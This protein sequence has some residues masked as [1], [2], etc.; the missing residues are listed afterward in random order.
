LT[1]HDKIKTT[2]HWNE[3]CTTALEAIMMAMTSAPVLALPDIT[4][5]FVVYTAVSEI[6]NGAVILQQGGDQA[7]RPVFYLS[8]KHFDI[9]T[10]YS[11]SER[12]EMPPG[13]DYINGLH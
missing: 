12:V 1:Q 4:K 9:V 11:G 8:R 2:E 13:G 10:R 5:P 7:L 6:P 3:R